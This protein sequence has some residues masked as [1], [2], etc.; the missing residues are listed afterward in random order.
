MA[1]EY[2][3]GMGWFH[4]DGGNNLIQIAE[5]DLSHFGAGLMNDLRP[6]WNYT[7]PTKWDYEGTRLSRKILPKH[8][9]ELGAWLAIAVTKAFHVSFCHLRGSNLTFKGQLLP[10]SEHS[11]YLCLHW[12][13]G[14]TSSKLTE[15]ERRI[16]VTYD[17][18]SHLFKYYATTDAVAA[19]IQ[20]GSPY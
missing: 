12:S 11:K 5:M 18:D 3:K 7:D 2:A 14:D 6:Q 16:V 8:L 1:E 13:G 9:W 17:H 15:H 10:V 19:I 20:F 4:N